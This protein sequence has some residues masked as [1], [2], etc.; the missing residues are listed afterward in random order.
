VDLD[1]E[2]IIN[3]TFTNNL[4]GV[5][6]NE[7]M[8]TGG[9]P[10]N[11]AFQPKAQGPAGVLKSCF[12]SFNFTHNALVGSL[13]GWPRENSTPKDASA[14]AMLD[15]RKGNGGDYRLCAEKKVPNCRMTSPFRKA[16]TDGKDLGAD[17]DAIHASTSGAE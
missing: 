10:K 14:V 17:L 11:C 12:S 2:K 8:S 4:V 13:G 15:F 6:S 16:G 3:F 7:I 5:G 9:G 1:R